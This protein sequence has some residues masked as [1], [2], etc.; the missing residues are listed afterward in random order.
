MPKY[1]FNIRKGDVLDRA[2]E[3]IEIEDP[4]KVDEEAIEAARDLLAEGDLAGLDRRMWAFEVTDE[5][6]QTVLTFKFEDAVEPDVL[7]EN[8]A[9]LAGDD[10]DD[11]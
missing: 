8:E 3:P 11:D 5:S 2:H 1:H 6:G 9:W 7:S 10:D 4:E